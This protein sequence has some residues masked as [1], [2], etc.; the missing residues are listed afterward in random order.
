MATR[1]LLIEDEPILI[2]LYT[3]ALGRGGYDVLNAAD[4]SSAEQKVMNDHPHI[5]LLD[6]LIPLTPSGDARQMDFHEPTGFRVL[7]LVKSSPQLADTRVIVLTNLDAD[8]HM[9][10]ADRLGA[11]EYIIKANLNPHDLAKRVAVILSRPPR[12]MQLG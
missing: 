8:E 9:K 4:L 5:I 6:L 12:A 2:S 10:T 1:V 11:D 3:L 7:R